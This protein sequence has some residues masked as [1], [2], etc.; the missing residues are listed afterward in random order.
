MCV[1]AEGGEGGGDAGL[2]SGRF[3]EKILLQK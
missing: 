1:C 2:F 3:L